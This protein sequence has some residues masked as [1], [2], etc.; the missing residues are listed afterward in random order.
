MSC[1]QSVNKNNASFKIEKKLTV[2]IS[3]EGLKEI[4]AKASA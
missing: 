2:F 4:V 3:G 1:S